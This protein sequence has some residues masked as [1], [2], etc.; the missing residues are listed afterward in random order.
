[1]LLSLLQDDHS[2]P[3][4]CLPAPPPDSLTRRLCLAPAA[5]PISVSWLVQATLQMLH[6]Q[7]ARLDRNS[8]P[9]GPPAATT[10]R[11]ERAWR[12]ESSNAATR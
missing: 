9:S 4:G 6:F 12:S 3:R 5:C 2:R 8:S 1:M 11:E 10:G 7:G